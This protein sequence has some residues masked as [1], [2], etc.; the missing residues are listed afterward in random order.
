MCH[1]WMPS[2][3][4]PLEH[5]S[6]LV[7]AHLR[8]DSH[9]YN[10]V[11]TDVIHES[12]VTTVLQVSKYS[13]SPLRYLLIQLKLRWAALELRGISHRHS[14]PMDDQSMTKQMCNMHR[15]TSLNGFHCHISHEIH[16]LIS[17]RKNDDTCVLFQV[18]ADASCQPFL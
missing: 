8:I 2:R 6:Q 14:A 7:P 3:R 10:L 9:D 1:A 12:G 5:N 16:V 4:I 15:Q 17:Q 18:V 13:C 11:I